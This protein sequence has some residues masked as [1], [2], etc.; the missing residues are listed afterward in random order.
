[1]NIID[2]VRMAITSPNLLWYVRVLEFYGSR[3]SWEGWK[4]YSAYRCVREEPKVDLTSSGDEILADLDL[5]SLF[6]HYSLGKFL[7]DSME[8]IRKGDDEP[9]K[10]FLIA[11]CPKVQKITW[12][13][14]LAEN[15]PYSM[16]CNL[17]STYQP[18][19]QTIWTPGLLSLRSI[20]IGNCIEHVH[21]H[22]NLHP[23]LPDFCHLLL[24]P[25][26]KSL[27][28]SVAGFGDSEL[29]YLNAQVP[30]RS[31]SVENITLY[32]V[33]F[34]KTTIVAI[35]ER[36]RSLKSY[37]DFY[38]G[39]WINILEDIQPW[40]SE[41]LEELKPEGSN[42]WNMRLYEDLATL[43]SFSKLRVFNIYVGDLIAE[44]MRV[45]DGLRQDIVE[46]DIQWHDF[47]SVLPNTTEELIFGWPPRAYYDQLEKQ[48]LHTQRFPEF[49]EHLNRFIQRRGSG[50]RNRGCLK[51]ICLEFLER[52]QL[53]RCIGETEADKLLGL[54]DEWS[55]R[56]GEAGVEVVTC[57]PRDQGAQP[58]LDGVL[59]LECRPPAPNYDSDDE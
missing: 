30:A 58:P 25:N 8:R 29:E 10:T 6:Q 45:S 56:W 13:A 42:E 32:I 9:L 49:F 19:P 38:L 20:S 51:K 4:T 36:L 43:S 34:D 57:A 23:N 31:S 12:V 54:V 1:M 41:T 2:L 7:Q 37:R 48:N 55:V 22:D 40:F 21:P 28:I 17:I 26:L 46:G 15:Q 59:D 39:A 33:D 53:V 14:H 11:S 3:S 47:H 24:L 35:L 50:K 44:G 27:N 18:L 16:L 5:E 52:R